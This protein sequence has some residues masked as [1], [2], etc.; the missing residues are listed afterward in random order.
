MR[1]AGSVTCHLHRGQQQHRRLQDQRPAPPAQSVQAG[2]AH[3]HGLRRSRRMKA[4]SR[5]AVA[6][7]SR[8]EDS[9]RAPAA[10]S[11]AAT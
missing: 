2:A 1:L 3:Q 9:D 6:L 4:R 8:Q 10:S 7:T 11:A 5:A